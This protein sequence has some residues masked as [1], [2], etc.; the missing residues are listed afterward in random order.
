MRAIFSEYAVLPRA[1]DP[2]A[3]E[4]EEI[5]IT[6]IKSILMDRLRRGAFLRDLKKG[7]WI[8]TVKGSYH[9]SK[10]C[11]EMIEWLIKHKR[12]LSAEDE[13]EE[14]W[15]KEA[16]KSHEWRKFDGLIIDEGNSDALRVSLDNSSFFNATECSW[17]RGRQSVRT[18]RTSSAIIELVKP[19]L[20]NAR[21]I[22]FVDPYLTKEREFVEDVLPAYLEVI[23][24]NP[25]HPRIELHTSSL[26]WS[27]ESMS[28]VDSSSDYKRTL[29]LMGEQFGSRQLSAEF[30]VWNSD[31]L[32]EHDR[33]LI[34]DI[35]NCSLGAGFSEK[36]NSKHT[37]SLILNDQIE[38]LLNKID[39]TPLTA[40]PKLL[41]REF[42]SEKGSVL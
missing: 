4:S 27:R 2:N 39:I 14:N 31:D 24:N 40:L 38:D 15:I 41:R 12:L 18:F 22:R 23:R 37:V 36:R 11:K 28:L 13:G 34:T 33:Y 6:I 35:G 21:F 9:N 17:W 26:A 19:V 5:Y 7:E 29:K 32:R 30:C 16:E 20:L 25:F 10:P 8:K 3:Y 1:L 42:L